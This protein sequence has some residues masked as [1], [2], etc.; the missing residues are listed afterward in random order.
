MNYRNLLILTLSQSLGFCAAPLIIFAGGVT[1]TTLAPSPAWATLPIAAMVVGVAL[2]TVPAALVMKKIGR[3][4]GF[5]AASLLAAIAALAAAH[6]IG[7]KSFSLFC[8]AI[9]LI[10][11]NLAFIQ[12]YRFAAAES[13][14][15]QHVSKAISFVLLGG[16]AAG[17]LGP[18]LA[19]RTKNVLA[20]GDYAGSFACLAVLYLIVA[21]LL[22]FLREPRVQSEIAT[23]RGRPLREVITQPGYLIAVLGG[24]VAYGVMSFIMTATPISMH[25]IDGHSLDT[26]AGVIQSHV[27]AMY[28]PALFTG[29]LIAR[30]G[31][32]RV[33]V[34]GLCAT[35]ACVLFALSGHQSWIYWMALVLLGVGWNFQFLGATVMLTANYRPEERFKAQAVNDLVIFGTQALMSLSAGA[36]IHRANWEILNLITLPFLIA[37]LLT[38]LLLRRYFVRAA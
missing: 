23:G 15:V 12:Q 34:M 35:V 32:A 19:K 8:G 17:F 18:E 21:G 16:I 20:H 24:M 29:A 22:F 37:V 13:V 11:A 6:A 28:L 7:V 27:V 25:V 5:I 4:W 10:G 38:I 30:W 31:A 33:M 26:T 1:G 3:R 2:S 36:V 14:D 9:L